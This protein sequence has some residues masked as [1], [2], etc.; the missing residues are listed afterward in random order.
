DSHPANKAWGQLGIDLFK[1]SK[2]MRQSIPEGQ[3]F[4]LTYDDLLADPQGSV[5]K[6]YERFG[7]TPSEKFL[8]R[9]SKEE[10]RNKNYKSAH[11]YS[12]EQFGFT[13]EEIYN[14]LGDIMDE[15]GFE[16]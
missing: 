9:L 12:L 8:A 1:Y 15:F 11:T 13:K 4:S 3:F 14:E 10:A 7:W 2:Q 5:L 16:K 6:I